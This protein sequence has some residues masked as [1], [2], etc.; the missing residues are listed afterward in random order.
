MTSVVIPAYNEAQRIGDTVLAARSIATVEEVVVVDDGSTDN[1]AETAR[2]AGAVVH[3]LSVNG[4]KAAAV[5]VGIQISRGDLLLLLD[6]DLGAGALEAEILLKPIVAGEADM[7]IATFPVI[8]GRGGGMGIVVRTARAGIQRLTGRVMQAPLS[9]QRAFRRELWERLP[10]PAAGFGLETALTIDA[11]RAGA[12]VVEVETGMTHR[13]TGNSLADRLHRLR[14][15]VAVLRAL[16][17]RWR[18]H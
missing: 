18:L 11:L 12:R 6:A 2:Q 8:P 4:G 7:T 15:L 1:T 5:A 10:A 17:S 3:R 13:V 14:Q 9:G 16:C